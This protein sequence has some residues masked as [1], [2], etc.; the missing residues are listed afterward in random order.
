M[1]TNGLQEGVRAFEDCDKRRGAENALRTRRKR[2]SLFLSLVRCFPDSFLS[3]WVPASLKLLFLEAW[4]LL[5]S[6][7][8]ALGTSGEVG[9]GFDEQLRGFDERLRK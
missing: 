5:G 9:C 7:F 1:D 4:K 3:L 8:L 6:W 2:K